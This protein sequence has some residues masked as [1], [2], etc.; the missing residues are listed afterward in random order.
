[1]QVK[2]SMLTGMGVC[3][4]MWATMSGSLAS[5]R[6]RVGFLGRLLV[7]SLTI[8]LALGSASA[9]ESGKDDGAKAGSRQPAD[10]ASSLFDE[11]VRPLLETRCLS[12]HDSELKQSGLDLSTREGLM[13]GGS[14]GPAIVAGDAERSL[15]VQLVRHSRKPGMPF[16]SAK[17]S[18]DVLARLVEWGQRGGSL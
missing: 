7:L 6:S 4:R 1:M 17:L 15:L 10:P 14:R 8:A 2:Q 9:Q 16:M 13:R 18:D 5:D 3:G 11:H 12:C